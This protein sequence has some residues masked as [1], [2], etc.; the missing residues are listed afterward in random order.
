MK[1]GLCSYDTWSH[2]AQPSNC[3]MLCT[4]EMHFILIYIM[5]HID[6][7]HGTCFGAPVCYTLRSVTILSDTNG[8]CVVYLFI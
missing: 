3:V 7:F 8:F 6:A 4:F 5:H 2:R 1:E